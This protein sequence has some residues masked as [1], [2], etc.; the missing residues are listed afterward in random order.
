MI[1]ANTNQTIMTVMMM[2]LKNVPPMKPKK[3]PTAA[4]NACFGSL[5]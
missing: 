2:I 5:R 3:D 1:M 4:L